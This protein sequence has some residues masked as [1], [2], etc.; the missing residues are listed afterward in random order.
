MKKP[1]IFKSVRS[2]SASTAKFL[3]AAGVSAALLVIVS[4][5]ATTE[6]PKIKVGLGEQDGG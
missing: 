5:C 3:L 4:G 2:L 6:Q 1:D